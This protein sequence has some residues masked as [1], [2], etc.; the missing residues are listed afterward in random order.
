MKLLSNIPDCYSKHYILE[1]E[2]YNDLDKVFKDIKL[3]NCWNPNQNFFIFS[4][5]IV[6][7]YEYQFKRMVELVGEQI[8]NNVVIM[9]PINENDS[10]FQIYYWDATDRE[11]CKPKLKYPMFFD[12]KFGDITTSDYKNENDTF[13]PCLL[14]IKAVVWPP[15]VIFPKSLNKT[16]QNKPVEKMLLSGIEVELMNL[17]SKYLGIDV[18]YYVSLKEDWGRSFFNG[19]A[20]NTMKDLMTKEIDI[21]I[22]SLTVTNSR[23]FLFGISHP[24]AEEHMLVCVASNTYV[25]IWSTFFNFSSFKLYFSIFITYILLTT[26]VWKTAQYFEEEHTRYR[27]APTSFLYCFA[28]IIGISVKILPATRNT[29]MF[30]SFLLLFELFYVAL[31]ESFLASLLSAPKIE[32]DIKTLWDIFD[33]NLDIYNSPDNLRYFDRVETALEKHIL[34][35]WIDCKNTTGCLEDVYENHEKAICMEENYKDYLLQNSIRE[36]MPP[37]YCIKRNIISFPIVMI[38][39][40]TLPFQKKIDA[41]IGRSTAAGLIDKW[42]SSL[43]YNGTRESLKEPEMLVGTLKFSNLKPIFVLIA[44]GYLFSCFVFIGELTYHYFFIIENK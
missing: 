35:H 1:V 15:Y 38:M 3:A 44:V 12:C 21:A 28:V 18:E 16:L 29:R 14:K 40:K 41:I 30:L 27:E 36:G 5:A 13:T 11:K 37:I 23:T 6:S 2:N 9:L 19:S 32:Q 17:I 7:D 24:Y 42:F 34:K 8:L 31:Y 4:S 25:D 33:R 20:T 22:G 10:S 43:F 39:R 26:L